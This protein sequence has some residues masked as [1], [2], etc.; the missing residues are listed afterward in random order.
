M[1]GTLISA[2]AAKKRAEER[3]KAPMTRRRRCEGGGAAPDA[4]AERPQQHGL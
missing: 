1:W 3:D 2:M 4:R